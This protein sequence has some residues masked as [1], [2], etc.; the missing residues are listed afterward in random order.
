M[1]LQKADINKDKLQQYYQEIKHDIGEIEA[2]NMADY[3][4]LS[5]MVMKRG[6]EKYGGIL[7]P[8]GVVLL[9][10]CISISSCGLLRLIRLIVHPYVFRAIL[11]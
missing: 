4:I 11:D 2:C 7:T 9:S 8:S 1:F 3:F 10:L 6:Q 5:Y